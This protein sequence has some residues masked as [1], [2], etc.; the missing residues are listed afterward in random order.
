M[1]EPRRVDQKI[2]ACIGILI[3]FLISYL[4]H[5]VRYLHISLE[6]LAITVMSAAYT[7]LPLPFLNPAKIQFKHFTHKEL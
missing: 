3:S 2:A 4:I 1:I 6:S 7:F 5:I